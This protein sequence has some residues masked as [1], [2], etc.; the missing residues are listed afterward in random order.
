MLINYYKVYLFMEIIYFIIGNEMDGYFNKLHEM[1]Q[2]HHLFLLHFL[3][4]LHLL[5]PL[6]AFYHSYIFINHHS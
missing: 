6:I 5:Y 3:Y 1:H 4:L 2:L